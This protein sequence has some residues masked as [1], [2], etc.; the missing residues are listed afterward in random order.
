MTTNH[1]QLSLFNEYAQRG[2][3]F[4]Y[5]TFRKFFEPN[6]YGIGEMNYP[7]IFDEETYKKVKDKTAI[8]N[9]VADKGK[10]NYYIGA[11]LIKCHC[12]GRSLM[13][14]K[15][16]G[17]Y[18]CKQA[19]MQEKHKK[20]SLKMPSELKV[21]IFIVLLLLLFISVMPYIFDFFKTIELTLFG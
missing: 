17:G 15:G 7:P 6:Y 5:Q 18:H 14:D 20:E 13:A 11:K 4:S 3:K 9:K 12:C 1:S 10:R 8:N 19:T 16:S 21:T 2:Y